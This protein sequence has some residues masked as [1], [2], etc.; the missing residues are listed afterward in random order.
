M[1]AFVGHGLLGWMG[2]AGG[3]PVGWVLGYGVGG[4][5]FLVVARIL[6]NNLRRTDPAS[7]KQRLEAEYYISHLLL[8]EL[9]QRGEDLAQ[10]EEPILQLLQ[11]ESG[12]R[13]QHGWTSLQSFYPARAEALADYKP[14]ASAEACRQQV[15]Q[16]IGAKA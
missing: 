7:L 2:A 14:E 12:D 6:S 9:A 8:A 15:E 1:G 4:L 11:A 10:Y 5:P 3:V 16:A 13:R